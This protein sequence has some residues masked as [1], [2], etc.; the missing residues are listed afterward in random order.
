MD[1]DVSRQGVPR[2]IALDLIVEKQPLARLTAAV[3]NIGG[4][5]QGS[6]D[7]QR[8]PGRRGGR[9]CPIPPLVSEN[10]RLWF[11]E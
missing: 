2:A 1:A 6:A 9:A 5:R 8:N 7:F 4:A 3:P 11:R 10:D